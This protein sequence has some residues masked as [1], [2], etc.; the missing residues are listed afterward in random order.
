MSRK[1]IHHD[2]HHRLPQSRGGKNNDRNISIVPVEKH[3]AWHRLFAN[4][5]AKEVASIINDCW[6]D[7]DYYFVAVPR[8]KK[9]GIK[10]KHSLQIN[11]TECGER[12]E[13]KDVPVR[14]LKKF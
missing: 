1:K 14:L 12:C 8:K 11:C 6:I 2:R 9:Q 13:I 7:P 4:G 3:R 5:T 10:H